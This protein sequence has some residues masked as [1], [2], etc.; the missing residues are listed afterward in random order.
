[1]NAVS[2]GLPEI[3]MVPLMVAYSLLPAVVA[4]WVLMMLYDI[5]DRQHAIDAR[6]GAIEERLPR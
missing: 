4:I 3:I 5:R 1:M 2:I 6:L